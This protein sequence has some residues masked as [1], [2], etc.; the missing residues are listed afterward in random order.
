MLT[1]ALIER[2]AM[3]GWRSGTSI[4]NRLA[5]NAGRDI[6]A[7]ADATMKCCSAVVRL[8]TTFVA[9][10]TIVCGPTCGFW[11]SVRSI[12][13]RERAAEL[14]DLCGRR[15]S[16]RGGNRSAVGTIGALGSGRRKANL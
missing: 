12:S 4:F 16:C 3:A 5:A 8:V 1:M 9:G 2:D 10:W 14:G 7:A 11:R 6:F 15:R 13:V